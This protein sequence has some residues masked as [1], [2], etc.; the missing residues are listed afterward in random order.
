MVTSI[1]DAADAVVAEVPVSRSAA[2]S[3]EIALSRATTSVTLLFVDFRDMTVSFLE[4]GA[5]GGMTG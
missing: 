1:S 4:S 2:I 5:A 3:A